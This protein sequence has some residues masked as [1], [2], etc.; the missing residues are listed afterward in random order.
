MKR[1]EVKC[2]HTQIDC[3]LLTCDESLNILNL[4]N[5]VNEKHKE[6]KEEKWIL[7]RRPND[8]ITL[9]KSWLDEKKCRRALYLQRLPHGTWTFW[10]AIGP[11][12]WPEERELEQ[13]RIELQSEN[14]KWKICYQS[15]LIHFADLKQLANGS[16]NEK[17]HLVLS[18]KVVHNFF[19]NDLINKVNQLL[20]SKRKENPN[21]FID[22]KVPLRL[23]TFP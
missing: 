16:P 11:R 8:I 19:D 21:V 7:Q 9:T 4:D 17:E 13:F 2:W 10:Q 1:H 5:H 18:D 6:L 3:P 12:N 14:V 20:T 22:V 15:H 23:I